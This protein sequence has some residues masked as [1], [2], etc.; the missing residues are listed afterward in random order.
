MFIR[1]ERLA[2]HD[3]HLS[4]SIFK[5]LDIFAAGGR[6][7]SAIGARLYCQLMKEFETSP[8]HNE[9]LHKF[10]I[11]R[12]HVVR[13]SPHDWSGTWCDICIEQTLMRS[14][15]SEGGLSRGRMKNNE[16]G[17]KCWVQTSSHFSELNKSMEKTNNKDN[18]EH[19][20]SAITRMERDSSAA[21]LVFKWLEEYKP[22]D[23]K[24]NKQSLVSFPA[25]FGSTKDDL[26]NAD[27]AFEVG[28]EVQVMMDEK[29]QQHLCKQSLMLIRCHHSET[30]QRL[31]KK[32]YL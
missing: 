25:G 12:N 10:A 21:T 16:S 17:H 31:M 27:R 18:V 11:D 19:K 13:Y 32:K 2:E 22:C 1:A 23:E 28:R 4:I 30:I 7:Q 24:R 15:K 20:D 29:H 6:H 26:V 9:M 14:A 3:Q 5:M 8:E